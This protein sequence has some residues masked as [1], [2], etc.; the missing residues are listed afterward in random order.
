LSALVVIAIVFSNLEVPSPLADA[1]AYQG[2]AVVMVMLAGFLSALQAWVASTGVPVT[3]QMPKK[4][5]NPK[6]GSSAVDDDCPD[7]LASSPES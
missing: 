5:K 4:E 2:S 3:G 7:D 6:R 1:E